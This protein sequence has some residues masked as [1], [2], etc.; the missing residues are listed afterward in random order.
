MSECPEPVL[1]G[2]AM[3]AAAA[4]DPEGGLK[5]ASKSMAAADTVKTPDTTAKADHDRRYA[6]FHKL[7]AHRQEIDALSE[8]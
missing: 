3:L 1:L 8:G 6:I 2:S 4:L 7:H 5:A